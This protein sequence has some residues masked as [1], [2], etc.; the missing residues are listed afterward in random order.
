MINIFHRNNSIDLP[1]FLSIIIPHKFIILYSF[2]SPFLFYLRTF[3]CKSMRMRIIMKPQFR[4][5]CNLEENLRLPG[6][7]IITSFLVYP[8]VI[9]DQQHRISTSATSVN[10]VRVRSTMFLFLFLFI[11]FSLLVP[12]V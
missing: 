1:R 4:A 7:D 8:C 12:Y 5:C 9:I 6:S 10:C 3:K 11:L 2:L